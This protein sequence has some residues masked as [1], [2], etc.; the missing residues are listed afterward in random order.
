[1][2]LDFNTCRQAWRSKDA[3][4]DGKFFIGV[5]STGIYCRPVCPVKPPKFKNVTFLKTAAQAHISGYRPCLRCRPETSPGTPVWS[6]TC[7]VVSRALRLIAEGGLNNH[8]LSDFANRLGITSRHLNRLFITHLGAPPNAVAQ[9][10]RLHAAKRL[11]DNT[12][13]SMIDVAIGSGYNSLRTFNAHIKQTYGVTPT[14]LRKSKST[15]KAPGRSGHYE[16][17]LP[18]RPPYNWQHMLDFLS[19]RA[20]PNVEQVMDNEY[21]RT[22]GTQE[23]PGLIKIRCDPQKNQLICKI[24]TT[25]TENLLAIIEK[26]KC[27]FDL[28]ADPQSIISGL[29]AVK[30]LRQLVHKNPGLRVPGCWD[31]FEIAVRS[32][33]G[34]QV[35]VAGA[36]T[37]I[38]RIVEQYGKPSK[39]DSSVGYLFPTPQA[40]A[41]LDPASLSMPRARANTIASVARAVASGELSF[42]PGQDP[43][44]MI[45]Q[46]VCL[47]GIGPWTAQYIAMRALAQP[48]ALL[49][50][51]LVLEKKAAE[52]YGLS[53]R[54][55]SKQLVAHSE[56]WRPWRAYA[57]MHIWHL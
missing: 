26:I 20:T 36:T 5:K 16:F 27:I 43:S 54:M 35:S 3:R 21:T 1:M 48:D 10:Q 18:Y 17:K 41:D 2:E 40:L 56:A 47:K 39:L 19:T 30:K 25:E 38:G 13:L 6:G 23:K 24:H 37:V 46:L 55:K 45:D 50:G 44:E 28:G 53:E 29:Q 9:T 49:E 11:L 34:Q 42:D 8:K 4:F 57:S 51:D 33:T 12:D 32:I 22:I 14:Q 15:N 31:G 7:A 52:L